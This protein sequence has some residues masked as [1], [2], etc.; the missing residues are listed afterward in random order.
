MT[1]MAIAKMAKIAILA[2]MAIFVM[3]NSNFSMVIGDIQLKSTKKLS[4]WCWIQ[5]ILT[6]NSGAI[7]KIVDLSFSCHIYFVKIK[8]KMQKLVHVMIK[9]VDKICSGM[10]IEP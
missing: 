6:F 8:K 10:L 9:F 7:K 3:P 4:Q 2:I 1:H 5:I